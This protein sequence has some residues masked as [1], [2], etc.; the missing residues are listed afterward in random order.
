MINQEA[1][2]ELLKCYESPMYFARNYIKTYD[3]VQGEFIP[4]L[5]SKK[6]REVLSGLFKHDENTY[7]RGSRQVGVDTTVMV[8]LIYQMLFQS[9]AV[10]IK[11]D[12]GE[13]ARH[14]MTLILDRISML[15]KEW[16]ISINLKNKYYA[17]FSSGGSLRIN[18]GGSVHGQAFNVDI[19]YVMNAGLVR[20][21]EKFLEEMAPIT[22]RCIDTLRWIFSHS[23]GL[24]D[25]VF[26]LLW[27]G[28]H[29]EDVLRY[30]IHYDE[31]EH[32]ELERYLKNKSYLPI[33]SWMED[34]ELMDIFPEQ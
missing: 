4:L 34:Y 6:H 1:A 3:F 26:K 17:E 22:S 30:T 28:Y 8:Y 5:I 19:I 24:P 25:G 15:P 2:T 20:H 29:E 21:L 31:V 7:I 9:Q 14:M 32:I 16:G 33:R 18:G 12:K 27:D 23:G 11:A 10:Y 13:T